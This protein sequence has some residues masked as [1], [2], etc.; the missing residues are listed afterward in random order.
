MCVFAYVACCMKVW[1]A[2]LCFEVE[3]YFS[4][5]LM[6][7]LFWCYI[8]VSLQKGADIGNM[9]GVQRECMFYGVV[10]KFGGS[11]YRLSVYFACFTSSPPLVFGGWTQ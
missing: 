10:G 11:W 7:V 5:S 2:V 8:G 6:I 9:Y 1:F 3:R 4:C